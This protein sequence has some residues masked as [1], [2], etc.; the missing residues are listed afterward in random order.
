MV[1]ILRKNIDEHLLFETKASSMH[2]TG[3]LYVTS[4]AIAYEVDGKGL[5]LN[6]V[7]NSL[8][9]LVNISKSGMLGTRKFKL[10]WIEKD[11]T[12]HFF[13]FRTRD[14]KQL[15]AILKKQINV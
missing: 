14:Y 10:I 5:Y 11:G 1:I 13:E 7:P 8:F 3:S 9:Q 15:E 12:K 4:H 6:F 2:G